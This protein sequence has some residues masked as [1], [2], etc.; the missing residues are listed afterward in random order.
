MQ[1]PGHGDPELAGQ[2]AQGVAA[3]EVYFLEAKT[4]QNHHG[5]LVL[6]GD[7]IYGGHGHNKGFPICLELAT[8]KV[9]WGGEQRNAG[10]G[11]AAVAY[12]DGQLHDYEASLLRRVAGLLYV[13]DRDSGEARLRVVAKLGIERTAGAAASDPAR[14]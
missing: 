7:H 14:D 12:A 11:S 8:G 2:A 10:T 5:G 1:A 4:M 6:V 3:E 13:S 9:A